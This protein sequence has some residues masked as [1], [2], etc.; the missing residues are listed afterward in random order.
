M[1]GLRMIVRRILD[2]H[3][4][5]GPRVWDMATRKFQSVQRHIDNLDFAPPFQFGHRRRFSWRI[6]SGS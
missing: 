3:W 1:C 6:D 5:Y 2:G 4:G